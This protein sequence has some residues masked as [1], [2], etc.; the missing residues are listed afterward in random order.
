MGNLEN[1]PSTGTNM[2]RYFTLLLS[3]LA[4]AALPASATIL[5]T[6]SF[7]YADGLLQTTGAANW[8]VVDYSGGTGSAGNL[9]VAGGAVSYANDA[10]T[11]LRNLYQS[12]LSATVSSGLS[13]YSFTFNASAASTTSGGQRISGLGDGSTESM[14]G[15]VWLKGGSAADTFLL[16]ITNSSGSGGD[17]VWWATDLA[18]NTNY[19]VVVEYDRSAGTSQLWLDPL[20]VASTSVSD[21]AVSGSSR[22]TMVLYNRTNVNLGN[23]TID[24]LIVATTF[25][26][27]AVPE[28]D[29][30]ALLASIPALMLVML[31]RRKQGL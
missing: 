11:S 20:S 16:G 8:T 18:I 31:R 13:Y 12:P 21:G 6:D 19:Q 4:L 10:D 2:K 26:E 22:S 27:V 17:A 9:A 30:F 15:Q 23:Y 28:P 14:R 24:D 3:T 25:A 1:N 5:L 7:I 29:V